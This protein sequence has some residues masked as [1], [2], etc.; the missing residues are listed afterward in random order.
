MPASCSY[1]QAVVQCKGC[2]G[3]TG[4]DGSYPIP[5][6]QEFCGS[7][8]ITQRRIWKAVGVSPSLYTSV[9]AAQTVR[10]GLGNTPLRQNANVNW[11]QM[12]DRA[13]AGV[14]KTFLPRQRTR[15]RPGGTRPAGKGVD[16][17]HGS[18]ERYLNRK[19][20]KLLMQPA[21][22]VCDVPAAG[23][24]RSRAYIRKPCRCPPKRRIM[25]DHLHDHWYEAA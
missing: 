1:P 12:S 6:D 11:N 10:D 9:L 3:C 2:A 8:D 23:N 19:K 14:E 22:P 15:H 17:K 5:E 25:H 13:V 16:V 4:C 20:G 24:K 18:Y 21:N 7:T